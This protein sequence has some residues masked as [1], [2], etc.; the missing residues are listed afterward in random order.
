MM[1][2]YGI[3]ICVSSEVGCNMGCKF[4]ESGRRKKVRGLSTLKWFLQIYGRRRFG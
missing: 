1:H 4:C 2:D 3:S